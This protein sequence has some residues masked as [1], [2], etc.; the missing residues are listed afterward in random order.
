MTVDPLYPAPFKGQRAELLWLWCP[1]HL[2]GGG[3]F[4]CGN[5]LPKL[6]WVSQHCHHLPAKS[7]SPHR[8]NQT[9]L[10]PTALCLQAKK[11]LVR[12]T[13]LTCYKH[14]PPVWD[15]TSLSS[16]IDQADHSLTEIHPPL[17]SKC[18]DK[19]RV[20][21]AGLLNS[22]PVEYFYEAA[23]PLL[24]MYFPLASTWERRSVTRTS[25]PLAFA[26][27][28]LWNLVWTRSLFPGAR[29]T[30]P[31]IILVLLGLPPGVS[32]LFFS[33]VH[34]STSLA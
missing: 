30:F 32:R 26:N 22:L 19:R 7:K 28:L 8:E 3:D 1:C 18:W 15:R 27:S 34:L 11:S 29:V 13:Q 23:N 24:F 20:P 4:W 31:Q 12:K 9:I 17:P 6:S 10:P 33:S 5:S 16:Y 21:H 14:P 2:L 25:C